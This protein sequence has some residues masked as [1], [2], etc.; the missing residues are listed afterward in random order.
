MVTN[1]PFCGN[2]RE[3][4]KSA[5]EPGAP[6][7]GEISR[8]SPQKGGGLVMRTGARGDAAPA[9]GQSVRTASPASL[10]TAA[11]AAPLPCFALRWAARPGSAPSFPLRFAKSRRCS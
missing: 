3:A 11:A 1:G 7:V 10:S 2:F 8:D 5:D 6:F 4:N 9:G